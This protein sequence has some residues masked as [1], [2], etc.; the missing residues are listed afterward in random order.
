MFLPYMC[1]YMSIGIYHTELPIHI[2][3]LFIIHSSFS[4]ILHHDHS[5][6]S[7]SPSLHSSISPF[8]QIQSSSISLQKRAGLAGTSRKHGITSYNKT[9]HESLHQ[10]WMTQG[11]ESQRAGKKVRDSPDFHCLDS[12]R[13]TKLHIYYI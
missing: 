13:N 4:H 8:P 9:R 6:S 5:S 2:T 11:K 1:T 12:H 7:S 10:G 3:Y